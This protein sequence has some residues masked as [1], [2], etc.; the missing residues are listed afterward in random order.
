MRQVRNK[1][2][3]SLGMSCQTA[4]QLRRLKHPGS[5]T[6]S[7]LF[8]WLICPL[9]STIKL[10]NHQIPDFSLSDIKIRKGRAYWAEFNLYFWH[11]FY[12]TEAD[13]RRFSIEETFEQE[14]MRWRHLRDRFSALDP[15]KTV[16]VVSNTQNN[17]HG[18]VFDDSE[19]D[20]YHFTDTDINH[21]TQS[22]A[23]Y[24]RTHTDE[25]NLQVV[26]RAERSSGLSD[27]TSITFLPMDHNE[28][29]G[30]KSS[31]DLWWQQLP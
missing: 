16:F 9:A 25:I 3:V 11:S 2:M 12:I 14:L 23:T 28:W 30:S 31:W 19:L 27:N 15:T 18:E 7:G 21:L 6:P 13:G 4:H 22:L 17:L 10:L 24:F 8:D 5:D 1:T 20:Q 26:T 29:K